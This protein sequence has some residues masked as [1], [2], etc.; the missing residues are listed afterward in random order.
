MARAPTLSARLVFEP[1]LT[2]DLHRLT[3]LAGWRASVAIGPVFGDSRYHA[4]Y[5]SV[6]PAL[7]TPTRPAYAAPAGYGGTQLTLSASRRFPS[8]WI[9]S[10]PRRVP[11]MDAGTTSTAVGLTRGTP[12]W[13]AAADR[14][15][16]HQPDTP[17][18]GPDLS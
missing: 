8:F 11:T 5:Y 1:Q 4:C 16:M 15:Y 18:V 2:L 3:A 12:V 10:Q 6:D 13:R 9:C 14:T 17:I 7:A